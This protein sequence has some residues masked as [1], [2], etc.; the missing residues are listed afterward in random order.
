MPSAPKKPSQNWCVVQMLRTFGIPILCLLR[1]SRIACRRAPDPTEGVF[2]NHLANVWID[3]PPLLHLCLHHF[4][5]VDVFEQSLWA[6]V[7]ADHA[8][9]AFPE[10]HFAPGPS[11]GAGNADIDER[12]LAIYRT[13]A[14][15][16]MFAGRAAEFERFDRLEAAEAARASRR[17]CLERTQR[18][19]DGSG[20]AR[21]RMDL[22]F[23]VRHLAGNEVDLSLDHGKVAVRPALEHET[24]TGRLQ[25]MKLAGINPHIEGKHGGKGSHD[26]LSRP[27]FELLIDNI[28]LKEDAAAHG[29]VR[30]RLGF[31]RTNGVFLKRDSV[32]LSHTLKECAVAG[33]TL[34]VQAK[35][36]DR[37]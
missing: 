13:P 29:K 6:G 7:A 17:I 20:L 1:V 2:S 24:A 15:D 21:V 37:S 9:P 8:I 25:V 11:L 23:G 30:H 35:I 5:L 18:R 33:R 36:R 31:E 3:T 16:R 34:G 32:T 28:G 4:H 14:A 12:P 27:A 19:T 10:R 26:F 22:D